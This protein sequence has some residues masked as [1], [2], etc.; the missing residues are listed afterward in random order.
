MRDWAG[1]HGLDRCIFDHTCEQPGTA[2]WLEASHKEGQANGVTAAPAI[3]LNGRRVHGILDL[4]NLVDLA[5]EEH[6]RVTHAAAQA[7]KTGKVP[8]T[9]PGR[10]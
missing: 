2:A 10:K 3:F 1:Q 8:A 5:E 9:K 7:G 4:E 6:E